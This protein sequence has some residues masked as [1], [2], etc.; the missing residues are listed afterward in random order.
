M[1]DT[2]RQWNF[3]FCMPTYDGN[4]YIGLHR[5]VY[6][7]FIRCLASD[8]HLSKE[9]LLDGLFPVIPVASVLLWKTFWWR[10]SHEGVFKGWAVHVK[11]I[12]YDTR[13]P[14][15][16]V[17]VYSSFGLSFF[18]TFVVFKFLFLF[19]GLASI[20]ATN[21]KIWKRLAT[22]QFDIF[23]HLITSRFLLV[24]PPGRS[25]LFHTLQIG[26]RRN[27]QTKVWIRYEVYQFCTTSFYLFTMS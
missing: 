25:K 8:T 26:A 20:I 17:A 7:C 10:R 18:Q 24:K 3:C 21:E 12:F 2:S 16:G 15:G 23:T 27:R 19:F 5:I 11:G 4:I 22:D 6:I 9:S 1:V 13:L 14:E